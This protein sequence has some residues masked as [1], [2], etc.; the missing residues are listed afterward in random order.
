MGRRPV[1]RP[2]A[3]LIGLR[4]ALDV[5][6][7]LRPAVG[8]GIDLLIV[9][10]LDRRPLLRR[11]WHEGRRHRLR[12]VRVPPEPGRADR[13]PCIR[14][15]PRPLGPAALRRQV[16]RDGDLADVAPRRHGARA[17]VSRCRAAPRSRRQRRDDARD[18]A[19]ELRRARDGE[20]L[21]RHPVGRRCRGHRAGS[22]SRPLRA[23]AMRI[24]GS[25]SP[26]TARLPTSS[27]QASQIP[28]QCSDRSR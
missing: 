25:S 21:W 7:N 17:G 27:A 24:L 1:R 14:A 23:S 19:V 18:G 26:C 4:K 28:P 20:H 3:G 2:E 11:P 15:C 13:A 9:R 10:E 22:A 5:Y 6:A 12:H 16:E 8:E